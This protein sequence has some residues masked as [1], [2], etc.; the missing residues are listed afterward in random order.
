MDSALIMVLF[1]GIIAIIAFSSFYFSKKQ[2]IK[3]SLSKIPFK[4]VNG[5]R[6]NELTK[7][8]G[9]ALHVKEPLIAP[10]SKLKCIFYQI[11]IQ[12]RVSTGKSTRWKTLVEDERMQ[13][14]FLENSG[15]MVIVKPSKAPKITNVF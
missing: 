2:V 3:R 14:F 7:I 1:I 11:K 8:Y 10:C 4:N 9:K 6:T 13:E 5:I 12:Q 15:D